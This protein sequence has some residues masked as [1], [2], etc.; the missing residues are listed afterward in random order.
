MAYTRDRR[1]ELL[2]KAGLIDQEQLDTALEHQLQFGGKIGQILVEQL[3]VS[4]E[5]LADTLAAQKGLERVSLASYA[6][7]AHIRQHVEAGGGLGESERRFRARALRRRHK[8]LLERLA[9]NLE[10]SAAGTKKHTRD[11]RLAAAR[12]V[13]LN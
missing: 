13:V 12:S 1:G 9:V 4:E 10:V 6:S 7:T 8:V 11:R 2:V 5:Q 3:I